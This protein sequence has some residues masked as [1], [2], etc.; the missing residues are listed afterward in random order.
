MQDT[1]QAQAK[2]DFTG[3]TRYFMDTAAQCFDLCIKNFNAK[4]LTEDEKECTNGCFTKQMLVYG[5]LVQ[6][7]S[8]PQNQPQVM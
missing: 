7:L 4:D 5:S 8:T 6:N 1:T 3:G 2:T